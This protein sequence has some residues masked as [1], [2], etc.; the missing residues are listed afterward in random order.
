MVK[1]ETVETFPL[2]SSDT[3][4]RSSNDMPELVHLDDPA[5]TVMVDF[6]QTPGFTVRDIASMQDAKNEMEF[7]GTHFMLV[8]NGD[9]HIKGLL[10][11]EDLLGQKPI[12]VVEEDRV[13]R[14]KILV[15]MLMTKLHQVPAFNIES[16]EAA[17]V[18]NILTTLHE[19]D[20]P[21]A[22]VVRLLEDG[23]KVLR[24]CFTT[25]QI[26]RQ[27]H[28]NVRKRIHEIDGVSELKD[29]KK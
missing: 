16:V 11:S 25:S 10:T 14:D 6:C 24:G 1:Y 18:G 8:V 26:S 21:F 12:K 27:L 28:S 5:F 17:R 19:I 3:I 22:L 13:S 7:H 29:W 2:S 23:E 15:R 20:S 4:L 9:N